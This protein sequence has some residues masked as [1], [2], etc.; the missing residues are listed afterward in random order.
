MARDCV[1]CDHE[2]KRILTE[3]YVIFTKKYNDI[4]YYFDKSF[5][6]YIFF[7]L[8]GVSNGLANVLGS[9]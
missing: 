3:H 2:V 9:S 6:A 7:A 5:Y 1:F 4:L 8:I